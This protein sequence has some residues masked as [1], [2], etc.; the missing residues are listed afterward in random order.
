MTTRSA[1]K[2]PSASDY[3]HLEPLPDPPKEPDMQQFIRVYSFASILEPHFADHSDVLIAGGGYLLQN[4]G[5]SIAGSFVP[6]CVF[7]RGVRDPDA[8]IDR[9]GYVISEVGKPPDFV[10]EVASRSTA[11]R[12]YTIK[13][14]GYSALGVTEY[15]RFDHTGGRYHDAPLAGDTLVDSKYV[16]LP[17]HHEPDGLIW[18]HSEAL[19]LDLCW[20]DG[21]LRFR[22]PATGEFLPTP[23]ELQTERDAATAERD[24]ATIERDAA[25]VERDAAQARAEAAEAELDALREK[26][27]RLQQD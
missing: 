22:D 9:N 4:T 25:T 19:G 26:L 5:D 14:E 24:A 3:S 23:E 2:P 1:I 17:T 21:N 18:G 27:R 6:D 13:R 11:R 15:W 12:D 20:D 10:L 8:I 16:P 7:V